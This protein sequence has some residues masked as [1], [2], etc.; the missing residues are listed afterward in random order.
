[1][2]LDDE[3]CKKIAEAIKIQ[4]PVWLGIWVDIEAGAMDVWLNVENK[5]EQKEKAA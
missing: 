3:L 4:K 5:I 1:M 2:T